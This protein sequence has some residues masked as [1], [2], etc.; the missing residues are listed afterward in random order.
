MQMKHLILSV[1]AV[2]LSVVCSPSQAQTRDGFM[3]ALRIG[4]AESNF[5]FESDDNNADTG[6]FGDIVAG[7]AFSNGLA[8]TGGVSVS[9]FVYELTVAG[10]STELQLTF[11]MY[12]L[13]GWYFLPVGQSWELHARLGLGN[14]TG[15]FKGGNLNEEDSSTGFVVGLGA[16]WFFAESF[17]LSIEGHWRSYGL[18]F[19]GVKD[20]ITTTGLAIGVMWK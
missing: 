13:S 5:N 14:T 3:A 8:L 7:Y 10:A 4:G 18:A 20:E 12:D 15:E 19:E 16:E 9:D 2:G 11:S 6:T 1:C 17:A